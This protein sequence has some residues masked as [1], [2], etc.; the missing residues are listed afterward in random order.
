MSYFTV[1]IFFL[2][3]ES[4]RYEKLCTVTGSTNAV[5]KEVEF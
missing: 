5:A 4:T 1:R 3:T 2:P